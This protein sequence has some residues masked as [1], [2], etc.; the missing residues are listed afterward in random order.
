MPTRQ[1]LEKYLGAKIQSSCLTLNHCQFLKTNS[2]T[3]LFSWLFHRLRQEDQKVQA[4]S[5]L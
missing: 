2:S 5:Q 3:G 1:A 4:L